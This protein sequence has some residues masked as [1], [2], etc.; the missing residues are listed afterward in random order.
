MENGMNGIQHKA[1]K[2]YHRL[3]SPYFWEEA[4]D[5]ILEGTHSLWIVASNL[6]HIIRS[7]GDIHT[8]YR[9]AEGAHGHPEIVE[10]DDPGDELLS[11]LADTHYYGDPRGYKTTRVYFEGR[12]RDVRFSQRRLRKRAAEVKEQRRLS[13]IESEKR[14]AEMKEGVARRGMAITLPTPGEVVE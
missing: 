10:S 12:T 6:H 13:L 3:T 14:I 8:E 2:L 9:F 1:R 4:L 7:D 5:N 11:R